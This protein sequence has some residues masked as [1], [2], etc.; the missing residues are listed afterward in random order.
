MRRTL[1]F[2]LKLAIIVAIAVWLAERPGTVTLKWLNW[3]LHS[4]VGVLIVVLVIGATLVALIHRFWRLVLRSP[5]HYLHRRAARKRERGYQ[6]L[7]QGMVAVA[8]GD[9]EEAKR[10]ARRAGALLDDPP[11]TLLLAAQ[12]AQLDG[13]EAAARG[14]FSRMI[15]R[16]ETSF[17]GLRGLLMQA[18]R[19]GDEAAALELAERAYRERPETPWV[20]RTLLELQIGAGN[21]TAPHGRS[22]RRNGLIS[23][24]PIS[25]SR[26]GRRFWWSR[27]EPLK[28]PAK[29]RRR[30]VLRARRSGSTL[31]WCRRPCSSQ[32]CSSAS[33][34]A[35]RRR[36]SSNPPGRN[37]RISLSRRPMAP[38]LRKRARL[39]VRAVSNGWV[40]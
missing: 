33:G 40:N 35:A 2:L 10:Q 28:R 15:E 16:E 24:I 12:A 11:L 29:E 34:R 9:A 32:A 36:V 7:T 19:S 37:H 5:R 18:M 20:I 23:W 6:A 22:C 13:D 30:C 17:L 31:G 4:S 1:L 39:I 25:Q 21:G 14:Y 3:E 38:S 26:S 8:A 27:A